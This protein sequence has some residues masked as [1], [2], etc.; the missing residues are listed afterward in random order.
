LVS[1]LGCFW[2]V[3]LMC[4]SFGRIDLPQ[5]KIDLP[6]R[7]TLPRTRRE[8]SRLVEAHRLK[9]RE[10]SPPG[11][12]TPLLWPRLGRLVP[13]LSLSP[14]KRASLYGHSRFLCVNPPMAS[15]VSPI[16]DRR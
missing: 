1:S 7:L 4:R 8:I 15:A 9:A 16:L 13:P 14:R 11:H 3:Q 12:R 6:T 2:L 10:A 5:S